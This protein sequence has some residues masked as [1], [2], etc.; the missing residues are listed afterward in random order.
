MIPLLLMS[1]IIDY[2]RFAVIVCD[3]QQSAAT[4][5]LIDLVLSHSI[6]SGPHCG[7]DGGGDNNDDGD[8]DDDDNNENG[9]NSG[10]DGR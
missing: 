9:E 2:T 10:D 6:S 5:R 7:D 8:A 1:E 3:V 4:D